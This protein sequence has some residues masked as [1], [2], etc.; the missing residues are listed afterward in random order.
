MSNF[1]AIFG[2][3]N[4]EVNMSAVGFQKSPIGFE[5]SNKVKLI[6]SASFP[7]NGW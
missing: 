2:F 4:S 7:E 3:S 1:S 5:K 6:I